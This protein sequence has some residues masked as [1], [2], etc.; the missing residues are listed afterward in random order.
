MC[1]ICGSYHYAE[2]IPASPQVLAAM[3]D[4]IEH[5]G[6]DD[7][8]Y[9]VHQGVALGMRR[10]SIIDL[11][12]G[13]QPLFNEDRSLTLVFNGE[14]Y[15]YLALRQRLQRAGHRFRSAGDGEVIVHLY[16]EHGERCVDYL[17]GMFAFAIWDARRQRLFLARDRM[18]IKPLYYADTGKRLLFGSEIKSILQ[19]PEIERRPDPRAMSEYLSLR[20]VPAPATLFE[21]VQALPPGF[22]ATV[23]AKGVH[24][25]RYWDIS[26]QP[27]PLLDTEEAALEALEPMFRESVRLR[28]MSDV[29]FGAFL[30]GGV[31]SSAVVAVMS[32]FLNEPVKTYAIGYEHDGTE[33]FSE[34]PFAREVARQYGTDHHE[35][36]LRSEDF[37]NLSEKVIWHLDQP[38]AD[39][40]LVAYH[41]VCAAAAEDVKMVL[42][43]EGGDELFAGY[44]RYAGERLAP[45]FG[46][47]PPS[48]AQLTATA[49]RALPGL[50]R[51]KLML[52]ALTYRD[53]G[54]R[55]R[56]WF[57]LFDDRRKPSLLSHG[58]KAQLADQL[59][60]PAFHEHLARTDADGS[61]HRMLYVDNKVYLPDCLLARG[62]KL[63][64]AS[65]LEARVPF[66]DHALVE[67]AASLPAE[68]KLKGL[69]RKHLLK[70]LCA[71]WLPDRILHRKKEG[72]PVPV[73][74]WLRGSAREFARDLLSP[75]TIARRGRFDTRFVS[76]LLDEHDRGTEDHSSMIVG[77]INLELW[78]RLYIDCAPSVTQQPVQQRAA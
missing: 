28:L 61:L 77:L 43:G 37:I 8:G 63:S 74:V 10:L 2:N 53:E 64:M 16:E 24:L 38:I 48:I 35:V 13:R 50:R 47:L 65:S 7:E 46:A 69:T 19:D 20:Y 55:L 73:G 14:I 66:L 60:G 22:T 5:R 67:L 25:R 58:F 12:T 30:S 72:F 78:H 9:F 27:N 56:N 75:Q 17:R 57:P 29:P 42:T 76:R 15:N 71:K 51:P 1:G 54:Q 31:D 62:D 68:F 34:L 32:E 36:M 26:Y 18:G 23:D 11:E 59:S 45:L 52:Q 3:L 4:V 33:R 40:A 44:G 6:P 39:A 70:R 21:Q 49:S 41:R